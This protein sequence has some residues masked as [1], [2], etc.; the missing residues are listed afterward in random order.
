MAKRLAY[1]NGAMVPES[2]AKV[3]IF[4]RGFTLGDGVF[5]TARTF[6]GRPFKLR[7]HLERLYDSLRYVQIDPGLSPEEME[8]ISLEVLEANRP[9]LGPNE[10]Y[11]ITQQV[12]RGLALKGPATVVI[13]CEPIPFAEFAKF[14]KTGYRLI[15]VSTRRE[16]PQC[17]DPK[18]K[19]ISRLNLVLAEL[20]AKMVDPEARSLMLDLEGNVT[21]GQGYNLFMLKDRVLVTP[22]S[23]SVLK[24]I[25]RATIFE[26]AADIGIEVVESDFQLFDVLNADEVFLSQTSR[27][28][29]PVSVVNNT[30][31]GK[32]VPGPITNQLLRL[33]SDKVGVD[34]VE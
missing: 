29:Q 17:L 27:C 3:S 32:T 33:W 16:P 9:L 7:E 19:T 28:L 23:R 14:Y 21:E 11:W 25:S 20:E 22:G 1:V 30:R 13:R 6:N 15:V 5:D 12:S 31:I 26:L 8:R 34:I 18:A 24:G 10:D 2:E 4:D